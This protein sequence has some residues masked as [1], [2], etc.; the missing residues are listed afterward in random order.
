MTVSVKKLKSTLVKKTKLQAERSEG[1]R[2]TIYTIVY[3]G[4]CIGITEISRSW[5]EVDDSMLTQIAK[6][7]HITNQQL[8]KLVGCPGT[9]DHYIQWVKQAGKLN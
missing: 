7:L 8:M 6:E 4:K 1:R 5:K 3:Q 2:H 9:F